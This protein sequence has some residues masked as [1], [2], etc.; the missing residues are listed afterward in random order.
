M[1]LAVIFGGFFCGL[2]FYPLFL[3]VLLVLFLMSYLR[4]FN[5][6]MVCVLDRTKDTFVFLVQ[7]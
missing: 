3:A 6:V 1:L 5:A 2:A 4:R 7:N